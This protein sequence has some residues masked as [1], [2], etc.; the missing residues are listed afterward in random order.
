MVRLEAGSRL[1][2]GATRG[3]VPNL[4]LPSMTVKEISVIGSTMG[5]SQDFA[6][7]VKF[8]EKHEI[9]PIL[10]KTFSLEEA[11]EALVRLEKGENLGKIV[12]SIPQ[13]KRSF[14]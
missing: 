5:S 8:V 3:P 4:L 7:M 2:F 12:L 9:R 10:D 14:I 13:D 1:A 6:D 11:T